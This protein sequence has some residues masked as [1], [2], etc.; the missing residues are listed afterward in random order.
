M[1]GY[2]LKF[3]LTLA[4]CVALGLAPVLAAGQKSSSC[5]LT[6]EQSKQ[7]VAAWVRIANFMTHEQRCVNCHGGVNP[8]IKGTGLDPGDPLAP[9]SQI[10][11]FTLVLREGGKPQ[12]Q[13]ASIPSEC[14]DCHNHM[15]RRRDGSLSIWM[16]APS[17]LT[18]VDV[19]TTTLCR[20]IKKRFHNAG[21]F[22]EELNDDEGNNNA[23][24]TAFQGDRGLDPDQFLDPGGPTYV[25]PAPPSITH[26]QFMRLGQ[27][28]ID[29]MGGKF[30]GDESCGC[31]LTHSQWS[32]QIHYVLENTGDEGHEKGPGWSSDWSGKSITT[33]TITLTNGVGTAR[34]SVQG[35]QLHANWHAGKPEW[36]IL[37]TTS[38][39]RIE[40][41]GQGTFPAMADVVLSQGTYQVFEQLQLSGQAGRSLSGNPIIGKQHIENC[42]RDGCK[43]A[44]TA[45]VYAP[46]LPPLAPLNGKVQDPN[47]V[48]G[49]MSSKKDGLGQSHQGVSIET[50]T[51]DLWRSGSTK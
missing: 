14:R 3:T 31:E 41:S 51:V 49:T 34:Y 10:S 29:A 44:D 23:V 12:A 30:Q 25:R 40:T 39:S 27:D 47:H 33:I 50:M 8:F 18:F 48:F 35:S 13:Q 43:G 17:F 19:D 46:P 4:G 9:P 32:G 22:M 24:R 21:E 6:E 45:D 5:P 42:D 26:D 16:T 37:P 38:S 2:D 7:A 36:K 28:W 15:V 1:R 11:H 20:R